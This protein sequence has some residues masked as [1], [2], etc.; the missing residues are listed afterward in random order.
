[1]IDCDCTVRGRIECASEIYPTSGT[2]V[3]PT[4]DGTGY[5]GG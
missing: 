3:A 1:M 4:Q 5:T 2:V